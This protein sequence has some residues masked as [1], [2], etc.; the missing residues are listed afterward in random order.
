MALVVA[1]TDFIQMPAGTTGQ[2]PVTPAQGMQRYN[3]D[4]GFTE[5]Y[6]G[7]AWVQANPPTPSAAGQIPFST[8]GSTYTST[9]KIV[10]G[11]AVA[12]TSGT[13]IDFT[14]IPSWAK[15][16]TVMLNGV[17]LSGTDRIVVQLGDSGGI[18]A[19]GYTGSAMVNTDN[20][21]ANS[22]FFNLMAVGGAAT[23]I[24]GAAVLTKFNG[25]IWVLSGVVSGAT[26][27]TFAGSKELSDV[28]TQVRITRSGTNTFDAGTINILYE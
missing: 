16:I 7:A 6:T 20:I 12:S 18:E 22:T 13:A 14:G 2:R 11:T 21:A 28:L 15:K 17:S 3:T 25:N 26:I 10:S 1:G 8:D 5:V 27:I 24:Y 23:L 19:T 9:A 4:L